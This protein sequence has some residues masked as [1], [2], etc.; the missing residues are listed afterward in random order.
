MR[1]TVVFVE[2]LLMASLGPKRAFR[3]GGAQTWLS[4]V[5]IA[6]AWRQA[7]SISREA[8]GPQ[9]VHVAGLF[10]IQAVSLDDSGHGKDCERGHHR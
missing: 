8:L 3:P 9:A 10:D 1:V 4:C 2:H 7:A 6:A 5:L